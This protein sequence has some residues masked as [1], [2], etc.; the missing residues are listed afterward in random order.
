MSNKEWDKKSYNESH[1]AEIKR[2]EIEWD[3][4]MA[5]FSHSEKVTYQQLDM[6][7]GSN[8]I[9]TKIEGSDIY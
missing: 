5:E 1:E 4:L 2:L 3:K 6:T 8:Y 7:E 9:I